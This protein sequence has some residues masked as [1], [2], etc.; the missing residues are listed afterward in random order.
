MQGEE[1]F[2]LK[3]IFVLIAALPLIV[4]LSP[5]QTVSHAGAADETTP[6]AAAVSELLGRLGKEVSAV[7]TIKTAFIQE[8]RLAVFQNTV[9]IKGRIYLQKPGRIAWH[10]DSPIRYSVVISDTS[11]RQWD[12]DT[13][14]VQEI[15]LARNPVFQNVLGQLRVWFSGDYG[16]LLRDYEAQVVQEN[17]YVF[18]FSPKKENMAAKVIK[19]IRIEFREDRKYLSRIVITELSGDS[20]V[21]T[22]TDTRFDVPFQTQDF[23]VKR[24]V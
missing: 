4:L 9:V 13:N 8:K 19:N 23:E 7:Q 1:H 11:I 16:S 24:R 18:R 12:E 5:V 15:S 14:R 20:T 17:P 22:F 3:K 6:E 2:R 10:V 21:I